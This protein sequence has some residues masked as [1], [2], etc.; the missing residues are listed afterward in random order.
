MT[1]QVAVTTTVTPVT[2][3]ELVTAF[4]AA[5]AMVHEFHEVFEHPIGA[6][7]TESLGEVRVIER[8]TYI[9]EEL[10]EGLKAALARDAVEV[11]DAMGDA[12]YLLIGNLVECGAVKEDLSGLAQ[13]VFGHLSEDEMGNLVEGVR[14]DIEAA[15]SLHRFVRTNFVRMQHL[16]LEE[17]ESVMSFEEQEDVAKLAV[18]PMSASLALTIMTLMKT[19]MSADPLEVMTAIHQSNMSKLLPSELP[20][21]EACREFMAANMNSKMS[22]D[23]LSFNRS[24]SGGW[25][26]KCKATGKIIKNPLY[27]AVDLAP[28]VHITL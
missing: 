12:V 15:G 14:L 25:I 10:L 28:L 20:D 3:Q 26:A 11:V 21:E 27:Q 8:M 7:L 23:E 24:A 6:E 17:I 4:E 5:G 16:V 13:E 22:A 9:N 1:E 18:A 19:S 2:T